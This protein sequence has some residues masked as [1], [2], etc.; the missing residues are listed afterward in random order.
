LPMRTEIRR[1]AK[2]AY[3]AEPL[4][5]PAI[6]AGRIARGLLRGDLALAV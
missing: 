6:A 4:Y 2:H 1:V 3:L 5:S